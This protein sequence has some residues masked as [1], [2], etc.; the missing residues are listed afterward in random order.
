MGKD[1]KTFDH[2]QIR[3]LAEILSDTGLTEIE[4]EQ[5]GLKIRVAR[6]VTVS[7]APAP[8]HVAVNTGPAP[9]AAAEAATAAPV[10]S[11]AG[12]VKSPMVGT[13]YHS[14]SPDAAPFVQVGSQV[15]A[16]QTIMIIEAMKTMNQ[17]PSPHA[18]TVKQILVGN[19]EPVEYDEPLMII[20]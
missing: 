5:D 17:I 1:S 18:G 12:T 7:Y 2:E 13:A 9:A 11:A 4:V 20:E 16:G 10:S 6:E 14:P 3:I 8:Q 19:G 15:K